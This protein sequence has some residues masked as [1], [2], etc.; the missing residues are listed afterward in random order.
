MSIGA[1][2]HHL[3]GGGGRTAVILLVKRSI[4]CRYKIPDLVRR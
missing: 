2:L 4:E 3:A 1:N